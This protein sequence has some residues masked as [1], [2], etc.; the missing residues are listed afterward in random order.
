MGSGGRVVWAAP[1]RR[2]GRGALLRQWGALVTGRPLDAVASQTH[3]DHMGTHH[4][5][6]CRLYPIRLRR[7]Q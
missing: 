1:C 2:H 7:I 3:F 6:S 5:F 4:E